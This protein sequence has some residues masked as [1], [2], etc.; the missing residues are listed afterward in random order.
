MAMHTTFVVSVLGRRLLTRVF[1]LHEQQV[2]LVL[3]Q[4]RPKI[5]KWINSAETEDPESL[6]ASIA[7]R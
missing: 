7:R 3:A 5:Q 2:S 1:H 4:A 6:G